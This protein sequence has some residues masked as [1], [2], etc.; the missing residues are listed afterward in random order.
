MVFKKSNPSARSDQECNRSAGLSGLRF[1]GTFMLLL[2]I[3]PND[4]HQHFRTGRDDFRSNFANRRSFSQFSLSD[5]LQIGCAVNLHEGCLQKVRV[6]D[7]DLDPAP[8]AEQ[9][10]LSPP[11]GSIWIQPYFE[12]GFPYGTDQWISAAGT[13]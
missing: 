4:S 7:S 13:S 10:P 8:H 6:F 3:P 11:A 5:G 12:S 2:P 1:P 9:A